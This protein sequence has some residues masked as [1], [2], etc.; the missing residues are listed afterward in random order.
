[1]NKGENGEKDSLRTRSLMPVTPS[2]SSESYEVNEGGNDGKKG[3][4]GISSHIPVN[5]VNEG[6]N[7]GKDS[8]RTRLLIPVARSS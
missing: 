3:S 6:G 1:M 8:L 7:D 5:Q 4:L 2:S